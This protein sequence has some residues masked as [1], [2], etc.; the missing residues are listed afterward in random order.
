MNLS[1]FRIIGIAVIG[2]AVIFVAYVFN[3]ELRTKYHESA[4]MALGITGGAMALLSFIAYAQHAAFKQGNFFGYLAGSFLFR[5]V[6]IG[7]FGR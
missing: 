1:I 3:N 7:M 5:G 2:V 6:L 4:P